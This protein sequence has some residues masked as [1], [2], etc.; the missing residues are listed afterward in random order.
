MTPEID[1]QEY[2]RAKFIQ[3]LVKAWDW[4]SD[5]DPIYAD[6]LEELISHGDEPDYPLWAKAKEWGFISGG[7]LHAELQRA[8]GPYPDGPVPSDWEKGI[9]FC[10][11]IYLE[12][13]VWRHIHG[14]LG[15]ANRSHDD[16]L[17]IKNFFLWS[18]AGNVVRFA[19]R[20]NK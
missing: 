16:Q 6:R 3:W 2:R 10:P 19:M 5:N 17:K 9:N 12:E 13:S 14:S 18:P 20:V 11:V 15:W 7:H 1:E 4:A 8:C